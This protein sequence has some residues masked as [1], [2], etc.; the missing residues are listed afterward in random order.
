MKPL[1]LIPGLAMLVR[2]KTKGEIGAAIDVAARSIG[3][4]TWSTM[5]VQDT[6]AGPIF[7]TIEKNPSGYD[8]IYYD[9]VVFRSDPVMQTIKRSNLPVVWDQGYYESHGRAEHYEKM[10]SFG[11]RRGITAAL[12]MPG[13]KHCVVGFDGPDGA[14]ALSPRLLAGSLGH[15]QLVLAHTEAALRPL[16]L[17]EAD[18]FDQHEPLTPRERECLQWT[19]NGKTAWETA[20]ILKLSEA[21]VSKYLDQVAK[22]LRCVSKSQSVAKGIR[23][24]IIA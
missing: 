12:H 22:K 8:D 1:E 5:F 20:Q 3:F 16:A 15:L 6:P 21:T 10:S 14:E 23:L 24:G 2:A 19:A 4:V 13:G 9:P 11:M 17:A 7:T 18:D